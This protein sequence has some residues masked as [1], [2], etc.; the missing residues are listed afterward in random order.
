MKE[1]S[2]SRAIRATGLNF[3]L[4]PATSDNLEVG[5]KS[6]SQDLGD[7]TL[8][9]FETRTKQEIVTLTNVGGRRRSRTRARRDGAASR[10]RGRRRICRTCAPSS[11]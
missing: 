11:P 9:L 8:A 5:V 7:A 10:P 2:Q 3:A 1:T 4:Q 6:R